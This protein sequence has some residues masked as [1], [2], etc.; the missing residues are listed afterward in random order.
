MAQTMCV[1]NV[2]KQSL[3]GLHV[4]RAASPLAR[5]KGLLGRLRLRTSEGLWTVPSQGVHTVGLA[6]PIDVIYID[7]AYRVIHLVENLSPFRLAP[8]KTQAH[9]V[10]QLAARAIHASRTQLGDQLIICNP[11]DLRDE[12]GRLKATS[13]RERQAKHEEVV[14]EN[15]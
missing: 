10:L 1:F 4:T 7:S 2:T 6:F 12:L 8:L 9:S 11:Y 5:L 3:L 14:A 13:L 15:R